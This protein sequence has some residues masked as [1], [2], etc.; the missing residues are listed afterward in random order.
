MAQPRDDPVT[1]QHQTKSQSTLPH[2]YLTPGPGLALPP[3]KGSN[4]FA[5]LQSRMAT[6][7]EDGDDAGTGAGLQLEGRLNEADNTPTAA[8]PQPP[9]A[10]P[11]IASTTA[12]TFA[13]D[14]RI[15]F[16]QGPDKQRKEG[17]IVSVTLDP[18]Q[19]YY[20]IEYKSAAETQRNRSKRPRWNRQPSC[21]S[22]GSTSRSMTWI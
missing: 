12:P 7:D 5:P 1:T 2:A 9:A 21:R 10:A 15:I 16:L 8:A 13:R 19:P 14:Q 18:E 4:P 11:T 3:A 17:K 20:S 6:G 22:W